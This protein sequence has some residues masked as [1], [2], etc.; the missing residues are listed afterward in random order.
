VPADTIL[1]HVTYEDV[2]GAIEWLT[3]FRAPLFGEWL[4][5]RV[6]TPEAGL[7]VWIAVEDIDE[8]LISAQAAGGKILEPPAA[9]GN[10]W[11]ATLRDPDGNS[12]GIFQDDPTAS[13]E[14]S[15]KISNGP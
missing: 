5:D 12:L 1:P 3:A 8:A 13:L 10:R 9:D 7:L 2:P 14:T 4:E 15:D 11:I 6:A